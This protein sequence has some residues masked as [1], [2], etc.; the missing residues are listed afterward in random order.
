MMD[1]VPTHQG[2]IEGIFA[3]IPGPWC[4]FFTAR[5]KRLGEFLSK[6]NLVGGFNPFEK[7]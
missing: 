1:L 6:R 5:V 4:G 7:Y 2:Q 3:Q